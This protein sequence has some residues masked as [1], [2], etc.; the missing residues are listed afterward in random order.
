MAPPVG[1]PG[2]SA[3]CLQIYLI[4][5]AQQVNP[6]SPA[7]RAGLV[8]GD[9]VIKINN[10]DVYNLK[11]KD[12][13][14]VVV[15]A[16]PAFEMTVQRGGLTWRPS[17]TP[18]GHVPAPSPV[19][20]NN[21][22]P[23]TRTSLA[24]PKGDNFGAVGTGHNL[25][26]KPF[27]PQVNGSLNGGPRLV[28]K[29][30]NTPVKLYSEDTI[31]ET[32]AAQSEVLAPG[33]VG[34]NFKKNEKNYD[35]SNSAVLR[36]LKETENEPRTPTEVN[37]NF[38]SSQSH[39]IGGRRT[40]TP[41]SE[42][43]SN[44]VA[45]IRSDNVATSSVR[46]EQHIATSTTKSENFTTSSSN[47]CET[48]EQ[49][50]GN[51][52]TEED[53]VTICTDCERVIVGVFVRIKDKNLHVECFKCST[54]G[55]SLK[56]V[57]YYNINNKLYCD[58][59]A[60][61]AA[62]RTLSTH[63]LPTPS[64]LS[65]KLNNSFASPY[66]TSNLSGPR[67]F[68]SVSGPLSPHNTL[69]RSTG[70]ISPVSQVPP[71]SY[72]TPIHNTPSYSPVSS[73][74]RSAPSIIWPPPQEEPDI[75]TAC[76]LFYPPPS[77]VENQLL[78]KRYE[79]D[80]AE[81]IISDLDCL[82]VENIN[83][84]AEFLN[85]SLDI[86]ME[87]KSATEVIETLTET[88]ETQKLVEKI[89]QSRPPLD[90]DVKL[91][92]LPKPAAMK[93]DAKEQCCPLSL[94]DNICCRKKESYDLKRP[95][96][97]SPNTVE[98][99]LKSRIENPVP[100]KW[101]SP[102]TQALRTM[103]PDRDTFAQIPSKHSYT[104]LASALTIA[105]SQPFTPSM[106]HDEPVPLPEETVP[107]F[108]PERPVIPEKEE[109][110]QPSKE[111][112]VIIECRPSCKREKSI[113]KFVKAL[114]SAPD[115]PQPLGG[116]AVLPKLRS[117]Q[118]EKQKPAVDK[119]EEKP[120]EKP[121][122]SF[123]KKNDPMAKY[124]EDLPTPQQKL[125]LSAALTIAPD[126]PYSPLVVESVGVEMHQNIG[127]AAE[128]SQKEAMKDKQ[129]DRSLLTKPLK[130]HLPEAFKSNMKEP[131]PPGYYPPSTLQAMID[132]GEKQLSNPT[133]DKPGNPGNSGNTSN[134][135]NPG[136][137]ENPVSVSY[138][139]QEECR[140]EEHTEA[141]DKS[142]TTKVERQIIQNPHVTEI[143]TEEQRSLSPSMAPMFS[144]FTCSFQNKG[145]HS[146]FSV[147]VSTTPTM[148]TQVPS[149][150]SVIRT[151]ESQPGYVEKQ[152][153]TEE[154][155]DK[156]QSSKKLEQSKEEVK[157]DVV[158]QAEEVILK[159][160]EPPVKLHS[161]ENVPSYQIHLQEE[162]EADLQF[163]EKIEKAE[164]RLEQR[165]LQETSQ[166]STQQQ[167]IKKP[168]ITV[169][170][171]DERI[172]EH[173]SFK[174]VVEDRPQS[175]TFSPRPTSCSPSRMNKP[176]P[177]LP[178]YQANLVPQQMPAASSNLL[179]PMS[180][181]VS[182]SPSPCPLGR[183][184]SPVSGGGGRDASPSPSPFAGGGR[185]G[186]NIRPV[187]PAQGPPENPM[188]SKEPL[189]VPEDSKKHQARENLTTFIPEYKSRRDIIESTQ[190]MDFYRKPEDEGH[191]PQ[192]YTST[193]QT[194]NFPVM[195]ESYKREQMMSEKQASNAQ[196]QMYESK[197]MDLQEAQR[198]QRYVTE[199]AGGTV[200]TSVDEQRK[201]A[202]MEQMKKSQSE[203]VERSAD[204]GTQIQRRRVVTEE[205]EHTQK[206]TNIQI[207]KH[208][209]RSGFRNVNV[210]D[211]DSPLSIGG[212]HYT[213]P[214]PM[215]GGGVRQQQQL[216]QQSQA[217]QSIASQQSC[218][219]KSCSGGSTCCQQGTCQPS[220]GAYQG[221]CTP[222]S[223]YQGVCQTS[224][225]A[226][227]GAC[228]ASHGTCQ[229]Q[230]TRYGSSQSHVTA[231][232]TIQ[233]TANVPVPEPSSE[234]AL[235]SAI[236]K[237]PGSSSK[238][239]KSVP[240]VVS[241]HADAGAGTGRQAGGVSVAPRRGRGVL[242]AAALAGAR[243]PL[244]A[245]CSM[246][247]RGPFITALGKIWCPNHFICA[248]PSCRRPLQDLGFV[249]EKGQLYCEYCFEKYLAP[250]CAKCSTKIKTD[251]LKAIGKNFHPECFNCVY[252]G[253]LFGNSSFFIEDGS[254]Y[255]EADWNELFTTKCFACGFPVEAGD[256]WVEALNNNYHSQCF[257]CTMCKKNLEGQ[258]FFAKG[259]R[260]FCK[261]HA[262]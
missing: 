39:A 20:S 236:K 135:E 33:V 68:S 210:P 193:V 59:H 110:P 226:Y 36:M 1:R 167:V 232:T 215:S 78:K 144:G 99:E 164:K 101:E 117:Q 179:D 223:A 202:H 120:P 209:T 93:E 243:I 158:K 122:P 82:E 105:P 200:A 138:S 53:T 194:Q 43:R 142:E 97:F 230:A 140:S 100:Q 30:Y 11:H 203:S 22:S 128:G 217:S 250:T 3:F 239:P 154:R 149:T 130:P 188:R 141:T 42:G 115:K 201:Q 251:C 85:P 247:I 35:A 187:S 87:R 173:R 155:H 116:V 185:S 86:I 137:M 151:I 40:A 225:S 211:V 9:A 134:P 255:C 55:T 84:M 65:P 165:K 75:P 219:Q 114:E 38:Y 261:N 60:K 62:Q 48:S 224:G 259:G 227:Q 184:R 61:S 2:R 257:N 156:L 240:G 27:A 74:E 248:T 172:N 94:P 25:S 108:P 169:Q 214:H 160:A 220:G 127:L 24:A 15:R 58:I 180:P 205:F 103:S 92:E 88:L 14:D 81:S 186:S 175:R 57:G 253:K 228:S 123:K 16:G 254:P 77:K 170:P 66:Q 161:R 197:M 6:G 212:I 181:A 125:S 90:V 133:S 79:K 10:V 235:P 216:I 8:P 221:T 13:Q 47:V 143:I 178:Y 252:C 106:T 26:A 72:N 153:I 70:P 147:E 83:A 73:T 238:P 150:S 64:P 107:Y 111:S 29:Q 146:Q 129:I 131:R 231:Q 67:P 174:P 5:R 260:P 256:R 4:L 91:S 171:E 132:E 163:M 234:P 124:F 63:S 244:C 95:I 104:P 208:V 21:I 121:K 17:V 12:A 54:C 76:P 126:R 145:E 51:N 32:L 162:A 23:V 28:N 192:M 31:A 96:H 18:T 166:Q 233:P 112:E 198:S 71:P 109:E 56:N 157:A 242:N 183:G 52:V 152:T 199:T 206:E 89:V 176:A 237:P 195:Q 258:S 190:G 204:G 50:V 218:C 168:V 7:E 44:S 34:V 262:R 19:I 41:T 148:L 182:R 102:L 196:Q 49:Q 245:S 207:E 136:N 189:P 113:S 213:N 80:E 69:P 46:S 37:R 98:C 229:S 222:G 159:K 118:T 45:S 246:Q 139:R 249:E 119:T 177:I 241:S 191:L